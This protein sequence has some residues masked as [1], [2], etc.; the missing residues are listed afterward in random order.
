M[1]IRY[2][3]FLLYL[4]LIFSCGEKQKPIPKTGKVSITGIELRAAGS[5]SGRTNATFQWEHVFNNQLQLTFTESS[6]ESFNIALDPNDFSTAYSIDLPFGTYEYS[7]ES[8]AQPISTSLPV[9]VSGQLIVDNAV[10]TLTIKASSDYGLFTFSKSNLSGSPKILE[11]ESGVFSS[12]SDFYYSY[13][14]DDLLLKAEL[15][16]SN[17]NSFRI[18]TA[19]RGFTHQHYQISSSATEP[20]DTFQ[21]NDFEISAERLILGESGYP[22]N[23]Y[24]YQLAELNPA[25]NET[26]GLQWI[27]GRI[28]SINDSGNSAEIQEINAETGALVRTIKVT[29]VPNVD[30]EDLT[31]SP[32]HLFIG[33]FGNNAGNRTD[34]KILKIS[35]PALLVQDEVAADVIEFSYPDQSDFSG[36]NVDHNFDCEA[37]IFW[38]NQLHLFSK[39]RGD[40]QTKHYTLSTTVD[41]QIATL[42]ETFDAKGLITGAD[43]TPEGK[44]VV[45]LG[46]ENQGVSSRCFIWTFASVSSSV[47]SKEG[48]QFFLGSPASLGQTEGIAIDPD[49][50]VTISGERI[51]FG[52]LTVPPKV[53]KVD[54]A[55]IFTP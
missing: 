41:K 43:V 40:G 16:L 2:P 21:P 23:L 20:V 49:R 25:T 28:F 50:E 31:A 32:T 53:F 17:G 14:K 38:E 39:N 42:T 3:V 9:S 27:Q 54:L 13:V 45:L 51:S 26:S 34:L 37:M 6:G 55:G 5:P 7:G 22:A 30:W 46:Y 11:P 33:D 10:E 29:N 48:N 1:K 35:I 12:T 18:G 36:A 19:S 4:L 24:P 15:D 8:N 52:S 47:F 44:H